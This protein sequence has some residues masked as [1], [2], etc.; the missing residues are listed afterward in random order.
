MYKCCLSQEGRCRNAKIYGAKCDGYRK[1]ALRPRIR[2]IK[3]S[4]KGS[5][6]T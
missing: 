3:K 5:E 1:C 2:I 6:K 4:K